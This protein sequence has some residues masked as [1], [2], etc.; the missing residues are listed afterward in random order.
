MILRRRL[1]VRPVAKLAPL[2]RDPVDPSAAPVAVEDERHELILDLVL[3][4][5]RLACISRAAAVTPGGAFASWASA[6]S[7]TASRHNFAS[8]RA[9]RRSTA[10]SSWRGIGEVWQS[11]AQI[12][13]YP[14]SRLRRPMRR[15]AFVP[16][17]SRQ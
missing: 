3:V 17:P 11:P 14:R 8:V 10:S 2:A 5:W 16:S 1:R 9:D 6:T 12:A 15:P 13:G 4:R 7:R